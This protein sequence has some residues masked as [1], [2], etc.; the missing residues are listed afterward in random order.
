VSSENQSGEII[1]KDKKM[2]MWDVKS[3]QGFVYDVPD[4]EDGAAADVTVGEAVKSEAYLDMIDKYKDSCNVTTVDESYFE[5]P[6]DIKFQDMSKLL[7][8]LK[9]QMPQ[10]ELPNQ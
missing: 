5:L 9:N 2:Y 1:M 6:K 3:K 10:S 7:E 8:D 4:S